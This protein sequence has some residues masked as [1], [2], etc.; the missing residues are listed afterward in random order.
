MPQSKLKPALE[1][2]PVIRVVGNGTRVWY[3]TNTERG[4]WG[5]I[6]FNANWNLIGLHH[7]ED[8][9]YDNLYPR[10]AATG[11]YLPVQSST[12]LRSRSWQHDAQT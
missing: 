11:L 10:S 9:N 1:T 7:V 3:K 4:S 6:C 2:Q 5:S 8:P 12:C